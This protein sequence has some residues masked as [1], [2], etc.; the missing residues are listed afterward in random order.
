MAENKI[1][2]T[3]EV[4]ESTDQELRAQLYRKS[5][6]G[7]ITHL[8]HRATVPVRMDTTGARPGVTLRTTVSWDVSEGDIADGMRI[9]GHIL[10]HDI[11]FYA[12]FDGGRVTV[13]ED[14]SI[15]KVAYRLGLTE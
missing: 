4:A 15:I 14:D 10:G 8:T 6:S 5:D 3:T 7:C 13:V 9:W 12:P 2:L 1:K 11:D